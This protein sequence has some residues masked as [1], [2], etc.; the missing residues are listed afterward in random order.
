MAVL[1]MAGLVLLVGLQVASSNSGGV[2]DR[3]SQVGNAIAAASGVESCSEV[4]TIHLSE[5]TSLDLSEQALSG[6]DADDFEGLVRLETLDLSHNS[7]TALPAGAFDDLYLLR[8]LHLNNNLLATLP[9]DVFDQLFLLDDLTLDGNPSL[10]LPDG[11]FDDFSRFDGI[12]SNGDVTTDTG[13]YPH[14][15]SFLTEHGITSPEEFIAALPPLYKER[16]TVVFRSQAAA[17]DH[18][19]GDYPRIISFGADGRFTFAWNTDP[20]APSTF[21]DSVEFIRQN[22][23]DWSTGIIDFSG[24][25]P[26]ITEPASCAVCHGSLNK[27]LWGKWYRWLGTENPF[28]NAEERETASPSMQRMLESSDP[29]VQPLDFSASIFLRG[30]YTARFLRSPG[31]EGY[32]FA[33]GE[34][35]ALWS[36]RHAEV[37]FHRL[38]TR[39]RDFRQYAEELTCSTPTDALIWKF[40]EEFDQREHNLFVPAN[41]DES[42]IRDNGMFRGDGLT[43]HSYHYQSDGSIAEAVSF[44]ALVE[45]WQQEPIVRKLYRETSNEDTVPS[46]VSE[47]FVDAYLHYG[48]GEA[49]AEDELIQKIR[50]HFGYGSRAALDARASQN[51]VLPEGTVLSASFWDGHTEVMRSRVCEALRDG[52]PGSLGTSEDGGNV[53]VTWDAPGYQADSVTGYQVLRSVNGAAPNVHVADTGTT[54]TAWTDENPPAGDPIYVVRAIYDDYYLGPASVQSNIRATG[55]PGIVGTPQAGSTLMADTSGIGDANGLTTVSYSYRWISNDGTSDSRIANAAGSTYTLVAADEGET[56]KVKV[57]FT[58]DAGHDETLTSEATDPVA[59]L[60]NSPATGAPAITGTVQVGETLTVDTSDIGDADGLTTVSYSYQWISNDGTSDSDIANAAGSTHTLVAADG[61]KTIKVKVSF[62]DDAGHDETLTSPTTVTVA[63]RPN[64]PATGSPTISGTMP[65]GETLTASTS[66]IEDADGM[67]NVA[68]SYQWLAD[69]ADIAGATG[70]SYTL[71]DSEEGNAIKVRVSFTDDAG[72]SE[73]LTSPPLDPSRPYGLTAVVSD[74]TVVLNWNPPVAFPYLYD[75]QILRNRPELGET[76]PIVYVDTGTDETTYT[77][78]DVEPGVLYVYRVKAANFFTRISKAS[79]PVEI[80]TPESLTS[81]ATDALTASIH[82]AR[83]RHDGENSFTFELRFSETPVSNISYKTLR[84]QAF[85]AS[86]GTVTKARRL[87][88]P[89]NVRWEITVEP[90]SDADVSI[91]LPETTDCD[92]QGAICTA[93]GRML[94]AEAALTVA[95]PEEEEEQ[96]PPQNNPATGAPAINGTA[97]VGQTLTAD[98]TGIADE[99][100]LDNVSY[101][102]QWLADDADIAGATGATHTLTS[103]EQGKAIKVRVSFTDDGGND[104]SPTSVATAAVTSPPTPLT[105]SI[106]DAAEQH[107]GGN[108]F[109]FELRFSETPDSDF[110]YKTLRD[111]AFTASGGTVTNVRRLDP[112]GNVRWEITVQPSSDADVTIVLPVTTDCAATGA[113]CTDDGRMLSAEV[114]LIVQGPEE[115]DV[116]TPPQNNPATG[117][118]TISGTAQAG[119]PLTADPSGI[120]DAD[121]LDN[122]TFTYQ[123]LADNVDISGATGDSYTLTDSEESKAV[124]VTVSF[125][126]DAGNEES[127]TSA[128]TEAVAARPLSL[129]DF[130]AGDGQEV[131]ASALIQVGNLGRKNNETQDRA[132]YASETS[133]WHASG[134]LRDGSLAWNGMT[135]NRVVYFSETGSFRFN[136]ADDIHIG[137]SF[138]AGGVNRELTVWIQTRT[139]AVSFLTK[140]DIRNSGSGYI[141]FEAPTAIRSVLEGVSE[142]DLVIIAVSAPANS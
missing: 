71:T 119:E 106:H 17:R 39:H 85:T 87:D 86:G 10:E 27:P 29:R 66:G 37:L 74:G 130:D 102:Y 33:T 125:T 93:D 67:D 75:Y 68:Y 112:P 42:M 54:D 98:V 103:S 89:G 35:G 95:G 139:E 49:T 81:A 124:K 135:L 53:V 43:S 140:D 133:D 137:E 18:V 20:D 65:A 96:T 72:H 76:E 88:P 58:D 121:G 64:Q 107:D 70:A 8:T 1:I 44:L 51:E 73:T 48:E 115:E 142:G 5:V 105:A 111:R 100:G 136:E 113:V 138:S 128:A 38:K 69:D 91:V 30:D 61:G 47:P 59:P 120:A 45:L 79:E 127:L 84:D 56:I 7:L 41:I 52:K 104:E 36:W 22:D 77:D 13:D 46:R 134:E 21:R 94:S 110:G 82:D 109:T 6:L 101:A 63:S 122:A 131:L 3:T 114:A 11:M 116:Q 40:N 57:S 132:W 118:P 62:T 99:D 34:A 19:S 12:L 50:L 55:A 28:Y 97:Q 92:D 31:R 14:I 129:D 23:D 90:S 2:C 16:F 15:D 9:E 126:D 80:R 25:S 32:V 78:T 83:E 108:S 24:D 117:T 60:P 26:S 123:W 141:T 4:S